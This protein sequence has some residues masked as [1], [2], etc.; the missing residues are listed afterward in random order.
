MRPGARPI[1]EITVYSLVLKTRPYWEKVI[2][3]PTEKE[4]CVISLFTGLE[5]WGEQIVNALEATIA[6]KEPPIADGREH[7][8]N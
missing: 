4:T 5:T 3:K 8:T 1:T 6:A 7:P 2:E